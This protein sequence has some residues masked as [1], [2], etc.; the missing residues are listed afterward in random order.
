[1]I[2]TDLQPFSLVED[3]GFRNLLNELEPSYIIPSRPTFTKSFLPVQ[4]DEAVTKLK[5]LLET[6]EHVTLSTDGWTSIN[7]E[8]YIAVTAHFITEEWKFYPCLLTCFKFEERHTAQNLHQDLKRICTEWH[9][10]DN[11]YAITTDNAANIVAAVRSSEWEHIPC[12]AH[13]INLIVK[14]GLKL[15]EELRQKIKNI[16]SYFHRS[17]SSKRQIFCYPNSDESQRNTIKTN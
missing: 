17:S 1:M 4:F 14:D 2:I 12:F 6:T 8:G 7:T 9:I 16:I 13:T 15:I 11:V 3:L 10:S 5:T